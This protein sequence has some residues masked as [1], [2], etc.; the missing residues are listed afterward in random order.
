[1]VM[2]FLLVLL[3]AVSTVAADEGWLIN[4]F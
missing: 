3:F 2:H 1:M 4:N